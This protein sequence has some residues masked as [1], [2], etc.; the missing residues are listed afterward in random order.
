MSNIDVSSLNGFKQIEC[1]FNLFRNIFVEHRNYFRFIAEFDALYL[2]S[3]EN[4]D[5]S[6]SLDAFYD[7][8]M[9]AYKKG[10]ED[11][12]VKSLDDINCYYYTATHSLLELCKKLSNYESSLKQD[13][14]VNKLAEIE[15]LISILTSVLKA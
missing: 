10:L 1:F 6:L 4:G 9:S 2:K 11:K 7:I 5:Y 14:E 3:I 13:Q 8:F 12:S 15:M